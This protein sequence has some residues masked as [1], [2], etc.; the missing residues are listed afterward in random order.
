MTAVEAPAAVR[1]RSVG[2]DRVRGLAVLLMVLE[3]VTGVVLGV[4]VVHDTV[5]RL[6]MPLFMLTAGAV[7]VRLRAR[8]AWIFA[9][10]IA[11][12]VV[13]PW[14]GDPSI[15][16]QYVFGVVVLAVARSADLPL[17]VVLA[18]CATVAANGWDLEAHGYGW[19]GVYAL[20]VLGAMV[21]T[22]AFAW[23]ERLP[24]W[25]G[26]LGRHPFGLYVGH[27]LLLQLLVI[28]VNG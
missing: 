3:H 20:V 6:A 7:F 25:V 4:S 28:G 12:A 17:W 10:G 14:A 22:S 24:V 13:V 5:G 21:G 16:V 18:L 1:V 9:V 27:L 26:W 2:V 23:G 15:L 8:H 19:G 11:L